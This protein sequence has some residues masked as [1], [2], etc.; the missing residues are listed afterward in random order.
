MVS[1]AELG[2]DPSIGSDQE[3]GCDIVCFDRLH[4]N[5]ILQSSFGSKNLAN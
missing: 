2:S 1:Y 5:S 3:S 4:F